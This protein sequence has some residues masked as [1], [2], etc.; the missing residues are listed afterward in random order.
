MSQSRQRLQRDFN[1]AALEPSVGFHCIVTIEKV[2]TLE[3]VYT[4]GKLAITQH[5]WEESVIHPQTMIIVSCLRSR[6]TLLREEAAKN[7]NKQVT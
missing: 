4:T 5:V 6:L 3:D 1:W 7:L 2:R